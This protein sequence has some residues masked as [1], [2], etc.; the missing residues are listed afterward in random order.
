LA[1]GVGG[2]LLGAA[3]AGEILPHIHLLGDEI[4]N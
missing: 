2:A 4:C 3:H 1:S